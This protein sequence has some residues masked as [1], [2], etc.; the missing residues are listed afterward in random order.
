MDE[1]ALL[2][3]LTQFPLLAAMFGRRSRRFGVG[4]TIPDGPLAYAST[5]PPRPLTDLERTVLVLC[6]AGV[7]GWHLGMEH[8]A[9]GDPDAGCNYPVRLTGQDAGRGTF[10]HRHA[11]LHNQ[12]DGGT[13]VPLQHI[14][15]GQADFGVYD[16]LLSE[17][18]VLAFEYG[19]STTLPQGLVIWEAQFG[20]FA[21]GARLQPGEPG[22]C[23]FR[24][25]VAVER[26]VG[27]KLPGQRF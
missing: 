9:N 16:S 21:N 6:G 12:K 15:H 23:T 7:S 2:D 10:S 1:R 8:T 25:A 27:G 20:D 14:G 3:Q 17:E 11:I 24:Q 4:M 5:H 19:Y 13:Y 22:Q 26:V 18:A